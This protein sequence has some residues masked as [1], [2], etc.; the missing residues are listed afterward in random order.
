[1]LLAIHATAG[2]DKDTAPAEG[3]PAAEP[4]TPETLCIKSTELE[5][6]ALQLADLQYIPPSLELIRKAREAGVDAN[7]VYAKF[8][9]TGE[10]DSFKT[11]LE[12]LKETADAPLICGRARTGDR[13]VLVAAVRAG[14]LQLIGK[15]RLHAEVI[16]DFRDPYLIVR[17]AKGSSRRLAVDG[18]D[19]GATI[20][21]PVEWARPLFVQLV[22]TGPDGPRPVAERWVGKIPE[23]APVHSG[24]E[25]PE[26]WLMQLRRAS[27]ARTLRS[28]RILSQE[29]TSYA[30][31]IC[32]SGKLGHNLDAAG[33]PEARLLKRGIEARVVGEAV[34]RA[35][36]MRDALHAIED[37]PSHRLTVTDARFTDAGYG[38]AEDERGRTCAVI[39]LA[40]WPRKMP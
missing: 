32:E 39:L 8:G 19:S 10:F 37:S 35:A 5:E 17:D 13:I 28:N 14:A 21:L 2:A 11:W 31:T 15:N 38:K 33:D 24:S 18:G 36:T 6:V 3:E 16:E 9:V 34:A 25:S 26:A 20:S 40:S 7:P 30:Q 29:A 12:N 1:M 22:A 23:G 4:A 27:G